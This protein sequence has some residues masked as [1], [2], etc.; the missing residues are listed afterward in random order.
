MQ[1][2]YALLGVGALLALIALAVAFE[3]RE[4]DF[5]DSDCDE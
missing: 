4:D 1:L 5:L 2:I 3:D